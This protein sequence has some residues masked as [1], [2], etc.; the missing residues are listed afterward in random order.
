[1]KLKHAFISVVILGVMFWVC[2]S[3]AYQNGY[4]CGASD[5]FACWKQQPM[6]TTSPWD[7]MMTGSRYVWLEP[8]GKPGFCKEICVNGFLFWFICCDFPSFRF[9]IK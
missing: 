7:G 1:M 2:W 4:A 3:V 9:E 6:A 5:E 8:G